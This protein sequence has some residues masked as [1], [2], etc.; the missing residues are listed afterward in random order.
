MYKTD[1]E[2]ICRIKLQIENIKKVSALEKSIIEI[3]EGKAKITKKF[4][5][6]NNIINLI[7][8]R[9]EKLKKD[10]KKNRKRDKKKLTSN[11]IYS[12]EYDNRTSSYIGGT[13]YFTHPVTGN[14]L[15][16]NNVN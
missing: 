1:E 3:N 10:K 14:C 15:E 5:Y 13:M 2:K 9:I 8:K 16:Y 11:Y 6:D 7:N 4:A 12:G